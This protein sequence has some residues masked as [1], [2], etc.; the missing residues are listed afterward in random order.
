MKKIFQKLFIKKDEVKEDST[1]AE[2]W[3]WFTIHSPD[4]YEIIK[5][6]IEVEQ[7]FVGIFAPKLDQLDLN[8][9]FLVG[10]DVDGD[11][12]L[13]FTPDGVLKYV[14]HAEDLVASAPAINNWKFKALKR[15]MTIDGFSIKSG[16]F[17]FNTENIH[18]YPQLLES[19]PDEINLV[20][21]YDH[22]HVEAHKELLNGVYIFLD[23]YLGEELIMEKIDNIELQ[24]K[25][26][27]MT[28]LISVDKLKDYLIWREKEFLEKYQQVNYD[29]QQ[30]E[31]TL[32]EGTIEQNLPMLSVMN[33]HALA[34]DYKASHPWILVL[35]QK[36]E[37][38]DELGLP[39]ND[40]YSV[41]ESIQ[42]DMESFLPESEGYI[43]IGTETVNGTRELF[44]ACRDYRKPARKAKEIQQKY[45]PIV[46]VDFEIFKDKYW[47][48]FNSY[49]IS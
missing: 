10:L 40:S 18:F 9:N 43:Q 30:D 35:I 46:D 6:G 31:W 16:D 26:K 28:D 5:N 13:I 4:F 22:Y 39:D 2:F 19:Y 17:K 29:S 41:F 45:S 1:Y 21:V 33:C 23:N 48:T 8:L 25:S 36:Y 34:W 24:S 7:K 38:K 11:A 27:E 49:L 37:P 15:A 42:T 32:F 44:I 3:H 14:I 12:E 47:R 20:F